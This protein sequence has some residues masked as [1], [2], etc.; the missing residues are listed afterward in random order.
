[1]KLQ[2][3]YNR[4]LFDLM[5]SYGQIVNSGLN[6]RWGKLEIEIYNSETYEVIGGLLARQATLSIE[7][8]NSPTVWNGH[9]APIILRAMT[10]CHIN[11]AWILLEPIER[12]KKYILYGLGQEKLLIEHMK[13]AAKE[14]EDEMYNELIEIKEAWLNS[15]RR[16][17]LTEVNVG[18]WAGLNTRKMA[19]ES[20]CEDLYN[21]AYQPFSGAAH[22]M[23]HHISTH[24]LRT[25]TN[26]LHN[27]HKVPCIPQIPPDIDYVYRSSKYIDKSYRIFDQKFNINPETAMPQ[28]WFIENMQNLNDEFQE[29]YE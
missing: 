12:A 25:C 28:D 16:D 19:Q 6:E 27:F 18:N 26:P 2:Q 29:L 5:E 10:D 8:A 15:Q 20:G 14:V 11:L 22:N 24:N 17:F 3:E 4:K 1:M 7:L 13:E 23:W 21:Y 9:I